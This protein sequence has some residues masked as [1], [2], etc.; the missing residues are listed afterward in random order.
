[1]HGDFTKQTIPMTAL[2]FISA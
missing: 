1:V 2:C